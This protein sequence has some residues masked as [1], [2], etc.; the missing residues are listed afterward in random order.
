MS[1]SDIARGMLCFW[2]VGVVN[3]RLAVENFSGSR[4]VT[5]AVGHCEIG[6]VHCA[7]GGGLW[8]VPGGT[9]I[10]S[11]WRGGLMGVVG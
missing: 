8:S 9:S 5:V 1:G 3:E 6:V 10:W 2:F 7:G 4:G 11:W